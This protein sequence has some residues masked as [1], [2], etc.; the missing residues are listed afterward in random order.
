MRE[1]TKL[2]KNIFGY[3]DSIFEGTNIKYNNLK[4]KVFKV[5]KETLGFEDD[6]CYDLYSVWYFYR[7][8]DYDTLQINEENISLVSFL[9]KIISHNSPQDYIND[10]YEN[11]KDLFNKIYGDYFKFNGLPDIE[12][13]TLYLELNFNSEDWSEYFSGLYSDD[14][15]HIYNNYVLSSYYSDSSESFDKD[16]FNYLEYDDVTIN[17]LEKL[18][19]LNNLDEWPGRYNHSIETNDISSFLYE[20]LSKE[21][22]ES[23]VSE[24]ITE[25]SYLSS[26]YRIS[27]VRDYYTKNIKFPAYSD[28]YK[29]YIEI[30]YDELFQIIYENK[31]MNLSELK[32][33]QINDEIDLWDYYTS[34]PP[35]E[36]WTSMTQL[37][38]NELDNI[39]ERMY[40]VKGLD[41]DTLTINREE[42]EGILNKLNFKYLGKGFYE[43]DLVKLNISDLDPTNKKIK[44]LYDGQYHKVPIDNLSDWALGGVMN[45]DETIKRII[46]EETRNT[47]LKPT[48]NLDNEVFNFLNAL[49]KEKRVYEVNFKHYFAY[50]N[51]FAEWCIN[52]DMMLEVAFYFGNDDDDEN[53]DVKELDQGRLIMSESFLNHMLSFYNIR[54][55]YML[56]LLEEWF[57]SNMLTE[58]E[59]L[60]GVDNL[61][62]KNSE[63]SVV[64][65]G[66]SN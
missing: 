1:L 47:Y 41:Y 7:G 13:N 32:D 46:N 39:I 10:L 18:A 12:W 11:N 15:L 54:K 4:N 60:S 14:D 34:L 66:C 9:E 64:K 8:S 19:L 28:Y 3:L 24:Y 37:L 33:I 65:W 52:G 56:Y 22:F 26:E 43:N 59:N 57:E 21:D 40:E 29:T 17:L 63:I 30:P 55:N 16:E 27:A 36:D 20:N 44:I 25:L 58:L 45:L 62:F 23:L 2:E 38:N 6:E 5:L 50:G 42:L 61:Y 35:L 31:L 49:F 51:L 48:Q 53:E